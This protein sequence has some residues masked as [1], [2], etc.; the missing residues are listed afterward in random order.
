MGLL[1]VNPGDKILFIGDSITDAFRRPEEINNAFQ[2]GAG[3]AFLV[4]S[5][6]LLSRPEYRL[7]FVNRGISGNTMA[8]ILS[9]WDEDCLALSPDAICLLAGVNDTLQA[10]PLEETRSAYRSILARTMEKLPAVRIVLMEPY[11]VKAGT[12]TTSQMA[13]IAA[14]CKVMRRVACEFGITPLPLQDIFNNAL[15]SAPA[16]YWSYD[17]I[18]ATAAGAALI[19]RSLTSLWCLPIEATRDTRM[20]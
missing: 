5:H 20:R 7:T 13:D 3:Y 16:E 17:G 15:A 11:L 6:F 18:H 12:I 8:N 9:Q 1:P 10:R 14:R 4:A 19:A 2:L